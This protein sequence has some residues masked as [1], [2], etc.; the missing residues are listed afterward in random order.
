MSLT[1][2]LLG[3][4]GQGKAAFGLAV[5]IVSQIEG[6]DYLVVAIDSDYEEF[7]AGDVYELG[8]TYCL[9]VAVK[10]RV[11]TYTDVA[12]IS[13]MLK[14]PVYL[15]MQLRAY[16]G[17]PIM[18]HGEFWGTLNFSSKKPRESAFSA[19]ELGFIEQL[20]KQAAKAIETTVQG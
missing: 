7:R 8:D 10:R 5:G 20:A 11:M 12:Q 16:I 18:V 3:I 9:D 1:Q 17:A 2:E 4:L 13:D 6:Q 19:A 14:H 15:Y